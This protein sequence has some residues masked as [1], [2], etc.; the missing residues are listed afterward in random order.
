[1]LT[2]Q[3]ESIRPEV[4]AVKRS[5]GTNGI[6]GI[7]FN[8][9]EIRRMTD[10]AAQ[11]IAAQ[12]NNEHKDEALPIVAVAFDTRP[13]GESGFS[14]KFEEKMNYGI[15][16]AE[17]LAGRGFRVRFYAQPVGS[18]HMIATTANEYPEPER[19]YAVL[20]GTASHNEVVDPKTGELQ[21]GFK[22]FIQNAPIQNNFASRISDRI[23]GNAAKGVAQITKVPRLDFADAIKNKLILVVD[24]PNEFE[25]KR[26]S[27]MFKAAEL[28]KVLQEKFPKLKL[29]LNTMNGSASRL[30]P[31]VFEDLGYSED[32]LKIFNTTP[33]N[34]VSMKEQVMGFVKDAA[35]ENV[36]FAP[37]PTR[38]WFRGS[39]YYDFIEKDK[40]NIA[41]FLVDG[42]ADRLVL[43][44]G[45]GEIMPNQIG[46]MFLYFAYEYLKSDLRAAAARTV[47]TTSAL[48][49]LAKALGIAAPKVT[50]VGSKNFA[51]FFNDLVIGLE[52][53]GHI[54][55][56]Y[57]GTLFL[58][59]P[60]ALALLMLTMMA[61]TG[62]TWR[63][64]E[65]E[66]WQFV[67]EKTNA[68]RI[69]TFRTGIPN[70]EG[71]EKYFDLLARLPKDETLRKN[72]GEAVSN[73]MKTQGVLAALDGFDT[74]SP[75]GVQF[76]FNGHIRA[77]PRKSGTDG[78]VRF[79]FEA[80][81]E[82][83][84]ILKKIGTNVMKNVLEEFS[85]R[86]VK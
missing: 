7:G 29:V 86:Q 64:L 70:S 19:N 28:G 2:I 60:V 20:M 26:L 76:I 38:G 61:E 48:D 14:E 44:D 27:E 79:Y 82:K 30:L 73:E 66:M 36:R 53:S 33:L 72:F 35:G 57:A 81:A 40:D 50:D 56:R 51:P 8:I 24:D 6:R 52:E 9:D 41:A 1:M 69:V 71:A 55:F 77:M 85:L 32:K 4:L 49:L 37:D 3:Y 22:V 45:E 78:S 80:P 10:A 58:D 46:P 67:L 59:H 84:S 11:E 13:Q 75:G 43:E 25:A 62:K 47:P 12:W 65:N 18:G 83:S 16:M 68:P 21:F 17:I 74:T 23:N 15:A 31:R 42:D 34:D 63:Q 5:F 39:A 54:A